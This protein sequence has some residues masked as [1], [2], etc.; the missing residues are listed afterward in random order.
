M[1][2]VAGVILFV[3]GVTLIWLA[4]ARRNRI[5]TEAREREAAGLADSRAG[6]HPSLAVI[7]EVAPPLMLGGLLIV[8]LKLVLAYAMTGA[9]RWFSLFDLAGLLF[10]LGA[11]SVWLVLKTGYRS[12]PPP[13]A[14]VA[15][16]SA[17]PD[18]APEPGPPEACHGAA[19]SRAS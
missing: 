4:L 12:F 7:G 2:H 3:A 1:R 9:E 13:A 18:R 10:L 11:W 8:A 16:V 5:R 19:K 15:T 14:T 17:A 6:L